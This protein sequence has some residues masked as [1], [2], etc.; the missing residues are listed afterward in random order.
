MN[1]SDP[2]RLTLQGARLIGYAATCYLAA[3]YY[4]TRS[5]VLLSP[6]LD[7]S[8]LF[9]QNEGNLYN[10]GHVVLM[11]WLISESVHNSIGKITTHVLYLQGQKHAR[12]I[13]RTILFSIMFLYMFDIFE[14]KINFRGSEVHMKVLK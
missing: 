2:W 5:E 3:R 12:Q 8:E 7:V 10:I 9:W 13:P 4:R 1:K 14:V 6:Y 11:L